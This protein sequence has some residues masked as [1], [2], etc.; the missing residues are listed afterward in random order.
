M[1]SFFL[2]YQNNGRFLIRNFKRNENIERCI[3]NLKEITCQP[4]LLYLA[5]LI[6]KIEEIKTF[7]DK[8]NLNQHCTRCWW[9]TPAILATQETE[10]RRIT[11]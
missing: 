1:P 4:R 5:K 6:L 11:V 7:H 9:L 3:S 2:I 8:Q 10:S